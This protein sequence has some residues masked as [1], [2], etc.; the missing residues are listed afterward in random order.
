LR[1]T[2]EQAS[3]TAAN[4]LSLL[5]NDTRQLHEVLSSEVINET[6]VFVVRLDDGLE[7]TLRF[8]KDSYKASLTSAA[9]GRV[10][11][12]A[13]LHREH[14]LKVEGIDLACLHK[15]LRSGQPWGVTRPDETKA[16]FAVLPVG[17][18][19]A[20][21][22]AGGASG[23]S[24]A[25]GDTLECLN[26]HTPGKEAIR[27]DVR[28]D[29]SAPRK[30]VTVPST[31]ANVEMLHSVYDQAI[32]HAVVT[33]L[34]MGWAVVG[35]N[36]TVINYTAA[37][38]DTTRPFVH[39]RDIMLA[40]AGA[41]KL[42]KLDGHI[43]RPVPGCLC[44]YHQAESFQDFLNTVL[45]DQA[46]YHNDTKMHTTLIE[47][48]TNY[49]PNSCKTLVRDMD[50]MSFTNGILFLTEMRFVPYDT[51]DFAALYDGRVAR[52]HVDGVYTGATTAPLFDKVLAMQFDTDVA[53]VLY[54]LIGRLLFKVG[55]L[56]DWQ[57]M[58]YLVGL[59]GTGKSMILLVV[60]AMFALGTKGVLSSKRE[61]IFGMANI[62][63]KDVVI[64]TDM[65]QQ[66]SGVLA[67]ELMQG[68][69]SGEPMEIKRKNKVALHVVWTS[70][71]IM[72]SNFNPDYVN[73]GGNTARR[74]VPI[75]FDTLIT[76]PEQSLHTRI[77]TTELPNIIARSV[78]AYHAMRARVLEGRGFWKVVPPIMLE[79][80]GEMAA[81]TSK[82]HEFL[83]MDDE[84][85]RCRITREEG[86]VTWVHDFK[87]VF[88]RTMSV[89]YVADPAVFH[90]FGYTWS[91][92]M[93]NVCKACKQLAKGKC[94]EEYNGSD[95]G[96]KT[97]IH[98]MRLEEI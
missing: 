48:L 34:S 81:A 46:A 54:A 67:Q 63:E 74:I 53:E 30:R 77:I 33:N 43:W 58:P 35:N 76:D 62:H 50:M 97:V 89:P 6:A 21:R 36:N 80:K 94:C 95:R 88:E 70:P 4:I 2:L 40:D 11:W 31:R 7:Y 71:V 27:A 83:A 60:H 45:N 3:K 91:V 68:M 73:K 52:H 24:G 98:N 1:P 61:E 78:T 17:M 13:F 92:R 59:A 55:Q 20:S 56:D 84:E 26:M 72:G 14:A 69:V 75:R 79:W 16:L 90:A 82:L 47:Y 9:D 66:L 10:V 15:D 87:A 64:G 12:D 18:P 5:T 8:Y 37:P 29:I 25:S 85:R 19:A 32:Q 57:V 39:L 38:S 65:P 51:P 86:R 49:N 44:G 96:K 41:A 28:A 22:S 42:R 93:E 23:A